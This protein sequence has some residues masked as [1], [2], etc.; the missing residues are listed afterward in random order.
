M[1]AW[2]T[3][4]F[5]NDSA[6]DWV[7]EIEKSE[8]LDL[9]EL[10]LKKVCNLNNE[11]SYVE[12]PESSEALAAAEVVALLNGKGCPGLPE[13]I[14]TWVQNVKCCGIDK[15][16]ALAKDAVNIIKTESELNELWKE[17][18]DYENWQSVLDDLKSRL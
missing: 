16:V 11:G 2:G 15:L 12:E 13:E 18:D 4:I 14:K 6:S 1:G 10:A 8:G 9:V 7:Y 3:G 17:S 5:E